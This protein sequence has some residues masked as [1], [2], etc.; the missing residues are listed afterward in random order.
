MAKSNP[1]AA[2]LREKVII[3][4]YTDTIDASGGPTITWSNFI[5]RYAAIVPL[6]G[7]EYFTAQQLNVDINVR[8]RLRY[9]TLSATISSKH[10]VLWGTRTYDIL[11]V[12]NR[13]E[14]NKEIILMCQENP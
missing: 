8:I 12:I 11:T 7:T 5:T 13:K 6:N 4:S 2:R 1:L 14:L 9:D 3:Q 10:R